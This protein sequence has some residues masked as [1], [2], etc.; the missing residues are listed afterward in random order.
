M[1]SEFRA[2]PNRYSS[3]ASRL[4]QPRPSM[5]AGP[6]G[7]QLINETGRTET[8]AMSFEHFYHHHYSKIATALS[9]YFGDAG[10]GQ[11][12]ADEA[13]TRAYSRWNEVSA[14]ANPSGWVYRVG[15][16][17]GRSLITR[18]RR[19]VVGVHSIGSERAAEQAS[20]A[21]VMPPSYDP[22][23]DRA[24]AQLN[25]KQRS[26]VICRYYLDWSTAQTAAALE[27]SPGTVKSRLHTALTTL[28]AR[29]HAD[30]E[31]W[32]AQ[33][34]PQPLSDLSKER[35]PYES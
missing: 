26:V 35:D 9:L 20:A 19:R 31:R 17:W 8:G 10:V 7:E 4:N 11:E 13:M 3:S 29:V 22:E 28:R 25:P 23:I 15:Q 2:A 21:S 24:V 14:A 5:I 18:L 32:V 30:P 6:M 27:I 16:N 33:P 34:Q 12:A 1:Q